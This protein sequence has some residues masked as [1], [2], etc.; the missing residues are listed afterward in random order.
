MAFRGKNE[1]N[2]YSRIHQN[3]NKILVTLYEY[4]MCQSEL[5]L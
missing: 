5:L 2:P 3:Q 4:G 1:Y